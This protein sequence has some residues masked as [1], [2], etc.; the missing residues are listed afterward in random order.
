[1]CLLVRLCDSRK[2]IHLLSA[3]FLRDS[4]GFRLASPCADRK[5]RS[6]MV[7]AVQDKG[8]V[9]VTTLEQWRSLVEGEDSSFAPSLV[10]D[11]FCR[12]YKVSYAL[13][14]TTLCI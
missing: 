6:S 1:L 2:I 7:E 12:V 3:P 10:C 9:E 11:M 13:E 14:S 5:E 4:G 8:V